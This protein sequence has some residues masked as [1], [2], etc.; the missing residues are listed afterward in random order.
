MHVSI[1]NIKRWLTAPIDTYVLGLFRVLFGLLMAYQI[2][3]YIHVGLIRNMFVLPKI[4]FQYDYLRWIKPMPETWMNGLLFFILLCAVAI[5]FGFLFKWACRL[6][7]FGYAYI[8]LLDKSIYNNHIYLFILLAILL[9]FTEADRSF[10]LRKNPEGIVKVP[11]WQQFILQFQIAIVYFYGGIAK[12]NHDWLFK[13]QPVKSLLAQMPQNHPL[14]FLVKNDFGIFLLNYGGFLIDFGAP[15]LLWY[16]PFR[17]WGIYPIIL[18]HLLN[19]II[20][21]DIGVFPFAMVVSILLFFKAK[22]LPVLKN[23]G[24][25][26]SSGLKKGKHAIS[27]ISIPSNRFTLGFLIVYFIFQLLFPIRGYFLPNDLDWTT[28]GNRFSWRMKVDTREIK[29]MTFAI[30]DPAR[31]DSIPVETQTFVNDMQIRNMSMDPR[32]I[33][34]FA[35]LLKKEA[36]ERGFQDV[37][38]KTRFK[39]SYNG[40][41]PQ[42]FVSPYIDMATVK[43][44]PFKTLTWVYPI[45]N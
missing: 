11:R 13:C 34:D 38:I 30:F 32:S 20:F 16:K 10:S 5:S 36:K 17:K 19:S 33:A 29:E 37:Q 7:A 14:A 15:A 22:E 42:Y 23:M 1:G 24:Q 4:N 3:D 18:F 6:F 39:V 31:K 40:R 8:L 35:A 44:Q 27:S 21:N 12:L 28:I 25:M 2:I 41:E 45:S 9:S 43:Y 26:P